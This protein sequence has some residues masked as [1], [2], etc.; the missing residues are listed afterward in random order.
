MSAHAHRHAHVVRA[1]ADRRRLWIA[2]GLI[3][4][5]MVVEVVAG[6]LASSLALLSD[7]AHMLTDAGAIALALVAAR[8]A[9]RPAAGA[10]T[11]GMGRAEILSAQI[12]GATLGALGLV[13]VVE[14][15]R[16]LFDP[17]GVEGGLV[18]AVALAGIVVNLV[19]AW[20]LSG[21][22]R[23]SLNVEGSFQHV[24][25]DLYA[26]VATAVAAGVILATGFDRA[27]PIAS[28]VV[29]ALMLYSAY[30]LLRASGRVFLEAAPEGV[31][32]DAIGHALAAQPGVVEVHDLHVWE[33]TSGF[34]ALSAHVVVGAETDCHA[35]RQELED[36]LGERFGLR[37]TTLQVEHA[38]GLLSIDAP[39]E[40]REPSQP[41]SPSE[42]R[43]PE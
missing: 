28:L 22:G 5:F 15:V 24:L 33:V 40:A 8:L 25:T 38:P 13:I 16:R 14:G 10:M 36:L 32:P 12:N 21:A 27:D 9:A 42:K 18:L 20:V 3:V 11:Y 4:A 41:V 26:F 35:T 30:G 43:Q 39:G 2:L 17:P 29:A 7:A 23:D 37:H 31:D 19:A 34:P 6:I 1:D